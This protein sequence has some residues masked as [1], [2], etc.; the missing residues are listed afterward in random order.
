MSLVKRS[1]HVVK[2]KINYFVMGLRNP[3]KQLDMQQ[4][5]L[6][7]RLDYTKDKYLEIKEEVKLYEKDKNSIE[8][9]IQDLNEKSR[10]A[11]EQERDELAK[12][13]LKKKKTKEAKL[14]EISD[15]LEEFYETEETMKNKIDNFKDQIREFERQKEQL[16]TR[17]R[18]SQARKHVSQIVKDSFGDMGAAKNALENAEDHVDRIEAEADALA[19]FNEEET[20]PENELDDVVLNAE[21]EEEFEN[22]GESEVQ[23]ELN[24]IEK[25]VETA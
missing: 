16:E 9:E 12:E 18:V 13:A 17:H 14:E 11:K 4:Q 23:Q 24:E 8:E 3:M 21:V 5:E 15:N 2:S 20:N 7:D 19:E 1:V 22:L 6:Q 10:V 25:E